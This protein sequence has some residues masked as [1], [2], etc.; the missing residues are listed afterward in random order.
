MLVRPFVVFAAALLAAAPAHALTADELIAKHLA[1]KGGLDK[2]RAIQSIRTTGTATFGWGDS[3]VSAET[4][5]VTTR[6]GSSR[7][8]TTIQGMTEVY[9]LHGK[10]GWAMDPFGGKK[11]PFLS[12]ADEVKAMLQGA[13]IDG[14]LVDYAKKGHKVEYLGTEDVDGTLAHKLRI[15]LADGDTQVLFFDPDYFLEIRQLMER[16]VR[17]AE[18]IRE[19]DFSGFAQVG[20]VWMPLLIESGNKGQPRSAKYAIRTVELNVAAPESLFTFPQPGV[21][22]TRSVV[23]DPAAA[24]VAASAPPAVPAS[25]A[26]FDAGVLSG[27]GA[28]NIGSAAMS[29]RVS[30]LAAS[31]T[32]GKTSLYVGAASGGVW[33]S[34]DGGTTFKPVFDRQ[35]VQSIGAIAID[36]QKN[37]TVWVGTGEAWTRNSTSIGNG[38][39]KTTDGGA[40]W[41]N[42]GLPQSERIVRIAID[43]RDS[44]KVLACVPGKLWSDS[45]DRGVYRTLDGGATWTQVLKGGN[46]STGCS[47]LSVDAKNPNVMLAGLWDFRRQGWTFRSGGDGPEAPSGSGLFMSSDGGATWTPSDGKGLPAKP[48]GRIEVAIAPSDSKVVYAFVEAQKS[49]LFRSDDGGQTWQARDSSQWMVWRPFYFARLIVDPSDANRVFKPDLALIVSEDGGKSFA[50]TSGGAHGDWHDLWIDPNNGKHLIGGDDGGLW[51]S[52]DGG[53]RW[54]K[55]DNLPISQFYHVAA[56]N[57][58]PYL[59][60]GGLQDNSSWVG[61]SAY[62][63]GISSAAWQNLYDGDGFWTIPDPFDPDI[64]Y[65][66]SQGGFIGRVDRKTHTARDIQPK[67][68]KGEKLRFNWN[69]PIVASRLTKGTIYLGGQFVFRSKDRG[70][71]WERISPDLTTNDPQKQK[72]EQS[73]GITVD[74]SSAE[75]HTTIYALAE[76]PLDSKLLW[77]G[78]DD[79]NLQVSQDAGKTWQNVVGNVPDLPKHSWV[80]WVEPSRHSKAEIFATFDRHTF[81]DMDPHA[82]KSADLGKTWRRIAGKDQGVRGYAHVIRQDPVK[83]NLLYLG[84]ELG[85]WVSIDGGKQWAQFSGGGFP[86]AAVRDLAVQERENDLVIGTHGRGIWIV[87]DVSPLRAIDEAVLQQPATFLPVRPQQQRMRTT[88]GWAD[89][90]ASFVGANPPAGLQIAYYQRSR[91]L[92]GGLHIEVVDGDGKVIDTLAPTKRRGLNRVY[93]HMQVKPPKVPRAATLAWSGTQAPRV[94]PGTY[95]VRLHRGSEVLESKVAVGLDRRAPYS[96]AD[97]KLQFEAAMKVHALFGSM[98]ALN[99]RIDAARTNVAKAVQAL[100]KGDDKAGKLAA[101]DNSLEELKKKIVATKE[102]GAITG[103]ERLREHADQLYSAILS[104]EGKPPAYQTA[105]IDV[106]EQELAEVAKAFADLLAKDAAALGIAVTQADPPF[107]N[108]PPGLKCGPNVAELGGG[109]GCFVPKQRAARPHR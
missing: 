71:S 69:S 97:R 77:A 65:A 50:G 40:T 35:P 45:A 29:G 62:P 51:I 54:H 48:W 101:L 90:D 75:M 96:V 44:N 99:D 3:P 6:A 34:P 86:S 21:P 37:T 4:A 36:P 17:G 39:Y 20:G 73:G 105:R 55:S 38:I 85:L 84:T 15:S 52:R 46:L 79:G 18:R 11:E 91:H 53:S 47:S 60:Y 14:P 94:L 107:G 10:V 76:S 95:T 56:D 70:E 25:P 106:L 66:E 67:A 82:F 1:A 33:K 2:I 98:A 78:T 8:E 19:T 12:S 80:S 26:V 87:D 108:L 81:G 49:G 13:D 59:V 42:M 64:V 88:G 43:P 104:Y 32:G 72:Q 100:A 109:K 89:G 103:E 9:A 68:A 16:K 102:G 23:A 83:P 57:R 93:W 27:L 74:N 58:D 92:F 41:Q 31:G 30:C 24:P 28:R 5:S 7:D 61:H 22:V 63:G